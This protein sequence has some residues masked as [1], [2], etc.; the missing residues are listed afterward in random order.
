M[1]NRPLAT[2]EEIHLDV[3]GLKV[4]IR[5]AGKSDREKAAEKLAFFIENPCAKIDIELELEIIIL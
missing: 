2:G 5:F 1:K 3:Y 4:H